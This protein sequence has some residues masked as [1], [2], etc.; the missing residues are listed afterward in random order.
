MGF[1]SAEA[2]VKLMFPSWHRLQLPPG[3]LVTSAGEHW[4]GRKRV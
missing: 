2:F 1:L 3:K 4:E